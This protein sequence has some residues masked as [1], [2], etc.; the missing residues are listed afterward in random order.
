MCGKVPSCGMLGFEDQVVGFQ[1]SVK[2]CQSQ[3]N[4]RVNSK[5]GEVG[6]DGVGGGDLKP[7]RGRGAYFAGTRINSWGKY[8]KPVGIFGASYV[9]PTARRS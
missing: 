8:E 6:R 7:T 1:P 3:F 9:H 2:G 5:N 4:Q